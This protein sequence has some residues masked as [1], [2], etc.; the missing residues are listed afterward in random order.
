MYKTI[1][2]FSLTF[3]LVSNLWSQ[4]ATR[5]I[6]KGKVNAP[7]S[8]LSDIYVINQETEK[9]ALTDRDGYFSIPA[10]VGDT[11]VFSSVQFKGYK[12]QISEEDQNNEIL[13][14]KLEPIVNELN[15]VV[16]IQYKNINAVALGIIP[17]NQRSYTPAERR[18]KAGTGTDA[19]FG[20]DTS[21][22]IDPLLNMFSGRSAM[23]RR[24][25]ET[26]KKEFWLARIAE[27]FDDKVFERLKIPVEYIKGFQY[28]IIENK[29]FIATLQTKNKAMGDFLL[30][31]LAVQFNALHAYD[32]K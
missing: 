10:K 22:S 16:I 7:L 2:S 9:N 30:G 31:E 1:F 23:L 5:R 18:L 20:L 8:N 24:D 17:A 21:F 15:D 27:L 6:L 29:N 14:V 3:L 4:E 13:Y 12:I 25:I 32:Q 11:L 28:Y 26:E 19:K